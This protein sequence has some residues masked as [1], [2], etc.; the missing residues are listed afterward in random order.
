MAVNA[1]DEA[2]RTRKQALELLHGPRWSS[3][4]AAEQEARRLLPE[5]RKLRQFDLLAQLSER[6]ARLHPREPEIRRMQTQALIE[7]GHA[8]AAIDVARASLKGLSED[9][10]EWSELTGLI[11]RA[12]KQV[13]IDAQDPGDSES[14]EALG[15]SLEAYAKP[16]LKDPNNTWHAI[17][18]VALSSFARRMGLKPSGEIRAETLAEQVIATIETKPPEQRDHWDAATLAEANL[19]IGDLSAVER[20]LKTYL[21]DVRVKAFDVGSTLRQFNQVWGLKDATD[22]RQ[23]GIVQAL[24]ARLLELPG[25][26]LGLSPQELT[27][28]RLQNAPSKAQL[29]AILGAVGPVSYAWWKTGLD[30]ACSVGAVYAGVSKRIGTSFLVRASDLKKDATD[31]LFVLTNFHVVNQ[32]GVAGALRPEDADIVFEAVDANKRYRIKDVVWSSPV[33]QHD[34]SL[35]RLTEVPVGIAP[36][37][38]ALNLPLVEDDARVYVIGYPAGGGLEFSFQDNTLLDHEGPP[39]GKPA[40]ANVCRVHYRAPTEKGSSGS[41][42]FNRS[43]WEVIALHHAGGTLS[44]LNGKLGTH[45]ANEGIA[46]L[47][48]AAAIG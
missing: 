4:S 34:A 44:Q 45:M 3:G 32:Q 47:S 18:L 29:E 24:R 20:H 35:L 17:N 8:T 37:P 26:E 2:T 40:I 25:A 46:L 6:V 19:A 12:Y 5:L 21:S 36:L 16:H 28:Q 41:P 22:D 11:G 23:Q 14:L 1:Q 42:V 10:P 27:L 48:I 9:H 15:Q 31:E 7:T 13:V 39:N 33:E 43:R 38:L 30:R